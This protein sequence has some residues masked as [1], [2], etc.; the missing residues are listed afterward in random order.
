MNEAREVVVVSGVRTAIGRYGGSLKDIP[1]SELAARVVREAVNRAGVEPAQ[2]GH[3]VFGNVIHTEPRDMYRVRAVPCRCH[4][5]VDLR[6]VRPQAH[7]GQRRPRP[8]EHA[9]LRVE[10]LQ[11]PLDGQP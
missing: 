4:E 9:D 8:E 11:Y 6:I 1:P 5:R 7:G 10:R 3:C 2:V